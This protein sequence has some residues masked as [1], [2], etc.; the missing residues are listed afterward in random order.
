MSNY[1]STARRAGIK[2]IQYSQDYTHDTS[3]NPAYVWYW[4]VGVNT[5]DGALVEQFSADVT[6]HYFCEF[7][8]R[9][10][11]SNS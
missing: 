3:A 5:T 9:V 1:M 8:D 6:V 2:S 10:S 7:Y 4:Q 11:L